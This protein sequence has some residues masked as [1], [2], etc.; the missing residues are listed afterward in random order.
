M[1]EVGLLAQQVTLDIGKAKTAETIEFMKEQGLT[2][3]QI[4]VV[5]AKELVKPVI[6]EFCAK[7][8]YVKEVV[9]Y[10]N[11]YTANN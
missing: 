2:V 6:D 4:D 7:S 3:T 10:I 8:A 11:N 9:D 1:K 5:K